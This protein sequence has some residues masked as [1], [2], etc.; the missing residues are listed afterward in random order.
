MWAA[1]HNIY[2][3]PNAELTV[4]IHGWE[5][6]RTS[7]QSR[8]VALDLLAKLLQ[9]VDRLVLGSGGG[10]PDDEG[11][12]DAALPG[13]D[14]LG[15]IVCLNCADIHGE[16]RGKP[17]LER[18]YIRHHHRKNPDH[19]F[20]YECRVHNRMHSITS[21][22]RGIGVEVQNTWG[23]ARFGAGAPTGNVNALTHG[24]RSRDQGVKDLMG[25]LPEEHR[26][27]IVRYLRENGR[28]HTRHD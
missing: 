8:Q 22:L 24:Q 1:L 26:P 7:Q 4:P 23:G 5:K 28:G 17:L 21:L 27:S 3:Q 19:R 10:G 20:S 14:C 16:W 13:P 15:V 12:E 6:R 11:G 18:R 25:E 2:L 9:C